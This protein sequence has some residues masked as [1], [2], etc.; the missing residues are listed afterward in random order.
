MLRQYIRNENCLIMAVSKATDDLANSES[1]K[2][3]REV[4]PE[5]LRTIGVLTQMDLIEE[6]LDLIKDFGNLSN[7]LKLGYV[8]VYLRGSK[9]D[10]SIQ[11]QYEIEREFFSLHPIYSKYVE[12]MGV[13]YLIKSLNVN[14]IKHIKKMLPSLRES[15][16]LNLELKQQELRNFGGYDRI[17][18]KKAQGMFILALLSKF[19]KCFNE[20]IEGRSI[21]NKDELVGGAR[22]HFI[23]TTIFNQTI[24]NMSPFQYLTDEDL[25]TA[26]RNGKAG[27]LFSKRTAKVAFRGLDSLRGPN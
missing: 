23:F 3:A 5:G 17:T 4:D 1:L 16:I 15:I 24:I 20:M 2:L 21:D 26:I 25:R 18:D 12:T 11:E 22:I 7:P 8:G 13:K 6:N 9:S 14:L 19:V 27:R 10:I